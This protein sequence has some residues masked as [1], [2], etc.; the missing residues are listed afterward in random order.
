MSTLIP[1][2]EERRIERHG[3]AT[4]DGAPVAYVV[5]L[6]AVMIAFTL[7]PLPLSVV[8]GFGRS[9]PLSQGLYGLV[10]WLLGPWAGALANGIG[11]LIG[12]F[13]N[14]QNTTIPGASVAGAMAGALA[15]GVLGAT[16]FRRRWVLP[17]ALL[18]VLEYLLYGGRAV[19]QNGADARAVLAG[20]FIN[21]SA[22]FLFISPLRALCAR[23]LRHTNLRYVTMALFFGTWISSGLAH[24]TSATWVYFV[25]N[26]PAENWWLMAP[27][28]P[29]EHLARCVIGAIVGTG[30]IAGL[31]AIGILKPLHAAY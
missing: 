1:S 5:A 10:G 15:A 18:F 29:L 12:V 7:V 31:R 27:A 2:G 14:P 23:W 4:L 6:T 9:F 21:W 19:V 16:G 13:I 22:L 8:I 20:S 25:S 3:G 28:A 24:L 30:V 11:V 26:W 17:L